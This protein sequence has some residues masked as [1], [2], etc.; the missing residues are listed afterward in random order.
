MGIIKEVLVYCS[1]LLSGMKI[2]IQLPE[3]EISATDLPIGPLKDYKPTVHS[4]L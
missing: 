2:W 1:G 4:F 3:R